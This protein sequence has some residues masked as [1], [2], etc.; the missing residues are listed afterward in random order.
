MSGLA[1]DAPFALLSL[2]VRGAVAVLTLRRPSVLNAFDTALI[3]ETRRA[4]K[5]VAEVP[6]RIRP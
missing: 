2:E 6:P 3:L 5:R 1:S 4:L